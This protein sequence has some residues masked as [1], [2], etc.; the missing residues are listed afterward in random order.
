MPHF[1]LPYHSQGHLVPT[2]I[3]TSK[4]QNHPAYYNPEQEA[5]ALAE[6]SKAGKLLPSFQSQP[7]G[8][9][10]LLTT[11][12]LRSHDTTIPQY[13]AVTNAPHGNKSDQGPKRKRA[14]TTPQDMQT[15][16][17]TPKRSKSQEEARSTERSHKRKRTN[18]MVPNQ[19]QLP[20]PPSTGRDVS[21]EGRRLSLGPEDTPQVPRRKGVVVMTHEEEGR[22]LG[23]V[24]V[25]GDAEDDGS[26]DVVTSP[27]VTN[28]PTLGV[29]ASGQAVVAMSEVLDTDLAWLENRGQPQTPPSS[30]I[31]QLQTPAQSHNALVE[32]SDSPATRAQKVNRRMELF[33]DSPKAAEEPM[34][35]TRIEMFGRV[36]VRK[37]FAARFLGLEP[38][39]VLIE[40]NSAEDAEG[41]NAVASSS[42]AALRPQWPDHEAPWALAG[43]KRKERRQKELAEKSSLLKRYL[44]TASDEG[45]DDEDALITVTYA[46]G[47]GKTA[48][49][50]APNLRT[51]RSRAKP[52]DRS[53]SDAKIALVN[54]LRGRVIAPLPL[55][56]MACICGHQSGFAGE[57]MISCASCRSWHHPHCN[58]IDDNVPL[59]S[60]WWCPNCHA[61]AIAMSTPAHSTPRAYAQ[62]DER[63][64][65][66]K[67]DF[68]NIALAPSPM[69]PNPAFSQ[70]APVTRTPIN[71][72]LASPTSREHRPR[73]L[74]YGTDMWA[75]TEDG[76]PSSV[77][78]STPGPSRPDRF[79][80][81]RID[82]LP[83]DVTSTPSRGLDF[84][85]GQPSLFSLTPLGPKGRVPSGVFGDPTPFGA[86]AR[87]T[88]A[89]AAPMSEM[90][91]SRHD[92][93]RDLNKGAQSEGPVT[94]S[95]R[96]P[97]ALLGAHN[98]SPSPFGHRRTVSGNKLSS[99]R[100][101]SKSGLGG[102]GLGLP[103]EK[104]D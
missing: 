48:H 84:T 102:L 11:T 50:L 88:T 31:P 37:T 9:A 41:W 32:D 46:R 6:S 100:S 73:V 54:S 78:P 13:Y 97:H 47:R 12:T 91:S 7:T 21:S 61:Q 16:I 79:S 44:E 25:A 89:G 86:R 67:G 51:P 83:F 72:V 27:R 45:S 33:K 62:S 5:Y 87:T 38:T 53:G 10:P 65:A 29:D 4:Y 75:Y 66:F 39:A 1:P 22:K 80:T 43:G 98:L 2:P 17:E 69:F 34:V 59:P 52:F 23:L 3:H 55:S 82:D 40:E 77:A 24:G 92:F 76:A 70:L 90:I 63:S 58:G 68:T 60:S 94:P 20:T 96:W 71:R 95:T 99:M 36:A 64:S 93:L 19:S 18:E 81:P 8:Q 85:F 56:R 101:S 103:E 26:T 30:T 28:A 42:R 14:P 104:E 35:S 57:P 49:R 15:P 74:S